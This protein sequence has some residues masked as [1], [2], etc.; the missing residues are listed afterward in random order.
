MADRVNL[1]NVAEEIFKDGPDQVIAVAKV[2]SFSE[3]LS[4][5]G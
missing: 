2:T 3:S 4:T 1:W 5:S